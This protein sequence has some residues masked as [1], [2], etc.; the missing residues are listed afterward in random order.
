MIC[1][2][3]LGGFKKYTT[4]HMEA[5]ADQ[6][7]DPV[8]AQEQVLDVA[9]P[10]YSFPLNTT[11]RFAIDQAPMEPPMASNSTPTEALDPSAA[12]LIL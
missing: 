6:P 4:W 12:A 10:A 8:L 2:I 1:G 9:I 3:L 11:C 7:M 5:A